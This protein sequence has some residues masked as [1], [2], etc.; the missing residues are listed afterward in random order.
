MSF[1]RLDAIAAGVLEVLV[2]ASWQA[3]VLAGMVLLVQWLLRE[4]LSARWRYNLWLLVLLRLLIPVTPQ[5]SLSVFNLSNHFRASSRAEVGS[6]PVTSSIPLA[7]S[8]FSERGARAARWTQLPSFEVRN[9]KRRRN[10]S[11]APSNRSRGASSSRARGSPG[12][13]SCSCES[14]TRRCAFAAPS[15]A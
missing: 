14:C 5:S 11:R 13:S 3:A 12:R 15:A 4:R 10:P 8:H 1:Q 2:R 9:R 7:V 6:A